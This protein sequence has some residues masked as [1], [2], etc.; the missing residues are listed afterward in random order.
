[1]DITAHSNPT[2]GK[3]TETEDLIC[4]RAMLAVRAAAMIESPVDELGILT[5]LLAKRLARVASAQPDTARKQIFAGAVEILAR[6][7]QEEIVE[8]IARRSREEV[9]R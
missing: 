9:A 3:T 4:D 7:F 8:N 1:M 2:G 6:R 5:I